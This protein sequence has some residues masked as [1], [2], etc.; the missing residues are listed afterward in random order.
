MSIAVAIA[1]SRLDQGQGAGQAIEDAAALA[2]VLPM[3]TAPSEVPE[4]LKVYEQ[5]RCD[6]AHT[7]QEFSRQSG[8]DMVNGE[9]RVDSTFMHIRIP[10]FSFKS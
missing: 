10:P 7:I 6:R 4:R 5:I 8:K 3:G 2:A 1:D 9:A